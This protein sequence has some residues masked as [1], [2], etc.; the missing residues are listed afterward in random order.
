MGQ[1]FYQ[2]AAISSVKR[3]GEAVYITAVSMRA[4]ILYAITT[5]KIADNKVMLCR[6]S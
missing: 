3:I 4:A 5:E 1:T 6:P 2:P